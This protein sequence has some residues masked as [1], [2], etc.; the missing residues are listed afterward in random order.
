MANIEIFL[1]E[2]VR[3]F[4]DSG[5]NV[6]IKTGEFRDAGSFLKVGDA[7]ETTNLFWNHGV[8]LFTPIADGTLEYFLVS[9]LS[10]IVMT[11]LLPEPPQE[12]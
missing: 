1:N 12:S 11:M 5:N 10:P 8:N 9:E 2:S 4:R 7:D 6:A 3:T